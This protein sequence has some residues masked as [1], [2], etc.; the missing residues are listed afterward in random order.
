MLENLKEEDLFQ[1]EHDNNHTYYSPESFKCL[2]KPKYKKSLL[3]K[4]M[5]LFICFWEIKYFLKCY[6]IMGFRQL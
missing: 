4:I 5:G 1:P 2:C 6:H 3:A